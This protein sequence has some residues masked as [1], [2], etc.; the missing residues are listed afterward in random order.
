V[1]FQDHKMFTLTKLGT[2]PETGPGPFDRNELIER[3]R[4]SIDAITTAPGE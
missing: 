3:R 2:F 1:V 4:N